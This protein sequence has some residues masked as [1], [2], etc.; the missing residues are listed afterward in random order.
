MLNE[1]N[2]G[3]P[4]LL[5]LLPMQDVVIPQSVPWR[6]TRNLYNEDG[7]N[8]KTQSEAPNTAT[9]LHH[10]GMWLWGGLKLSRAPSLKSNKI[11]YKMYGE[12]SF[13]WMEVLI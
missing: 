6:R 12:Q 3:H 5:T 8:S 9:K 2:E 13:L 10:N 11:Q 7:A 4:I 1:A